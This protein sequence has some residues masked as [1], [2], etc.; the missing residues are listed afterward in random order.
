[1]DYQLVTIESHL[2]KCA[3]EKL[4]LN[5]DEIFSQ[6]EKL[7]IL[8]TANQL[9]AD[10]LKPIKDALPDEISYFMIKAALVKARMES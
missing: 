1:M 9:G 4:E 7:L 3:E 2:I 8:D 10:K 6:D 5:W